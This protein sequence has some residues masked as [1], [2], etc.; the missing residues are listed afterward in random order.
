M[1]FS[2]TEYQEL[3]GNAVED[4]PI[5]P[6][7]TESSFCRRR[8]QLLAAKQVPVGVARAQHRPTLKEKL[9]KEL[10]RYYCVNYYVSTIIITWY[11]ADM[12]S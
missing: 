2:P 12:Y 8:A 7:Q 10:E 5:L 9:Q 3:P 4:D 11:Y 6:D 1:I